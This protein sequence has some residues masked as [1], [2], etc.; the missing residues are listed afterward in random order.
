MSVNVLPVIEI[1]VLPKPK[2]A[3]MPVKTRYKLYKNIFLQWFNGKIIYPRICIY[4]PY[5]SIL[6]F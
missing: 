1:R 2:I 5:K 4:S 6:K 3:A